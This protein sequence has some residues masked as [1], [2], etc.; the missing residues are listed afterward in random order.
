MTCWHSRVSPWLVALTVALTPCRGRAYEDEDAGPICDESRAILTGEEA[1]CDGV[2]LGPQRLGALLEARERVKTCDIDLRLSRDLLRI[3]GERCD[4]RLRL[5]T[6]ALE[7]ANVKL[8]QPPRWQW[9]TAVVGLAVGLLFG[10]GL[11]AYVATR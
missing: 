5:M 4:G 1:D 9:E 3:E 7:R 10:A 2:L 11:T 8:A 6:E